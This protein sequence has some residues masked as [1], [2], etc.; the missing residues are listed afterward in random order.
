MLHAVKITIES[1]AHHA[2]HQHL[3]EIHARTSGVGGFGTLEF[4]FQQGE[5][6]FVQAWSAED[7]LEAGEDGREFIAAFKGDDDLIDGSLAEISLGVESFAHG[8]SNRR[9]F[10]PSSG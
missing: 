7:P 4:A 10:R 9:M 1:K 3:P 2:E 6:V 5:N 8:I